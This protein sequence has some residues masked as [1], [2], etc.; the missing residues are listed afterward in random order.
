MINTF[1]EHSLLQIGSSLSEKAYPVLF[2]LVKQ[3]P[4]LNMFSVEGS[5][6]VG[7]NL[8]IQNVAN[9]KPTHSPI[10]M[11]FAHT[12]EQG[13]VSSLGKYLQAKAS[14]HP[15]NYLTQRTKAG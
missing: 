10:G 1:W 11:C 2:P 8:E 9:S 14:D 4:A 3:Q 12:L 7:S 13:C 15:G 6:W 5:G